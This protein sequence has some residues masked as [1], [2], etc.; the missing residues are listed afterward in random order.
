MDA[1]IP[2][3]EV[4]HYADALGTGS[5]DGKMNAAN[6]FQRDHMSAELFVS[7]VMAGFAHQIQIKLA[8]H[9]GK[10]IRVKNF[11]KIAGVGSTL[12]FVNVWGGRRGL[13]GQTRI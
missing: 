8:E 6:A 13:V 2:A 12:N 11:E 10:G 7:V 3:I 9:D 1:A 5:P 4:A